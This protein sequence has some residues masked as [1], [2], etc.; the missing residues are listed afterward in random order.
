LSGANGHILTR[1][2]YEELKRIA[3]ARIASERKDLTLEPID[4]LDEALLRLFRSPSLRVNN[5]THLRAL[6]ALQ[7]RRILV[8]HARRRRK[9]I[10]GERSRITLSGLSVAERS[11]VDVLDLDRALQRLA[12]VS[13]RQAEV[14]ELSYFG[15]FS[16]AIIAEIVGCAERT[17][18]KDAKLAYAA[19]KR[20]L[21]GS[22]SES[23]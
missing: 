22:C 15:G 6:A 20:E 9:R 19:L 14:V 11:P 8:E 23:V 12:L 1:T 21:F 16:F 5:R 3:A 2:L 13:P 17:V 18:K 4:L 10:E 7:R